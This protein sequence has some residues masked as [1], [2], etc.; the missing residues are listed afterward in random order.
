MPPIYYLKITNQRRSKKV[1]DHV[2]AYNELGIEYRGG[3]HERL[4]IGQTEANPH[5]KG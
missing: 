3:A 4:V 5:V 1:H 2:T